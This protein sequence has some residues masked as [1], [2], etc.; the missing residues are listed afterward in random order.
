MENNHPLLICLTATR[1]YGWVTKAFLKANSQ[2]ADYI[3]IVDQMSTDGTREMCAEYDNVIVI[4]NEDLTYSETVRSMLAL[5]RAREIDGDKILVYLAIDEVLPANWMTTED[6]QKILQSQPGDMFLLNWANLLPDKKHYKATF[7]DNYYRIFHDDGVSEYD[8]QGRDMHTHCLPW[9]DGGRETIVK[10]FPILHFGYYNT[11]FQ[12]V[13][14]WYYYQMVDYDKNQRSIITLS[15]FYRKDIDNRYEK[16]DYD[17]VPE[18]FWNDFDIFSL[19]DLTYVP[20]FWDEMKRFI[21]EKGISHYA[22]LNIWDE[23]FLGAMRL[24]DPR[25]FL[26]KLLHAYLNTTSNSGNNVIIRAID[27]VLKKF[28]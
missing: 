7:K 24:N 3:I 18:W 14:Q 6:G 1:N 8:N 10:D 9:R 17:N 28:V 22:K 2:W 11:E 13:K 12:T 27:K 26:Q 20:L 25:N 4:E 16:G 5:N 19:V 21:S 23:K 15:R